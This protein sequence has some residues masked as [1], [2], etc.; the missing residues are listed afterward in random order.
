MLKEECAVRYKTSEDETL[1]LKR[2]NVSNMGYDGL[3]DVMAVFYRLFVHKLDDFWGGNELNFTRISESEMASYIIS[4]A[5]NHQE[6]EIT[7]GRDIMPNLRRR[8][9]VED[10]NYSRSTCWRD[11]YLDSL[12]CS[13]LEGDNTNGKPICMAADLAL[14]WNE[15]WSLQRLH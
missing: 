9:C 5:T 2:R 11:C 14:F 7:P 13:L 4:S 3:D 10:P 15:R 8:P 1:Y 12:N 6:L